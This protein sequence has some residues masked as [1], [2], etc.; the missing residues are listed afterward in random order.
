MWRMLSKRTS[1]AAAVASTAALALSADAA[2]AAPIHDVFPAGVAC[3][4]GLAVDG[5]G[6]DRRVDRTFEDADGN[7]VRA[8]SAGVGSQSNT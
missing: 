5:V 2:I 8:I 1:A 3:T 4:F 7:P 6:G